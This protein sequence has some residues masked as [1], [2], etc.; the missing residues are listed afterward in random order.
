MTALRPRSPATIAVGPEARMGDVIE[1]FKESRVTTAFVA[2]DMS[3]PVGLISV[4]GLMERG[5]LRF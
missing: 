3:R 2:D 5:F 4:K 1:I